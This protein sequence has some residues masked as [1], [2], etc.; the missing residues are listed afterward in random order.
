MRTSLH[1]TASTLIVLAAALALPSAAL[2]APTSTQVTSPANPSFVNVNSD[3]TSALRVAGSTSGGGGNVDLRCYSGAD[4]KLVAANVAVSDG[5]FATDVTLDKAQLLALGY[6]RPYCVL[7]AVPTGTTPAAPPGA[8]VWQG[9]EIGWGQNQ[10]MTLGAGF[11]PNPADTVRDY[12]IGQ[13]QSRAWNDADSVSSCGICD[14]YLFKPGTFEKANPIW[15]ANGGIY[16]HLTSAFPSTRSALQADG[17]DVY[18]ATSAKS[19]GLGASAGFPTLTSS[20]SVDPATGDLTIHEVSQFSSC[21][22][23]PTVHPPTKTSCSSF[24]PVL[25]LDRTITTSH[26]GLQVVIADAWS[27]ADGKAHEIDAWYDEQIHATNFATAGHQSLWNFSWTQDGF[28][29]YAADTQI[30]TGDGPLFIKTDGTTPNGG[31]GM[32]PIGAM[33]F[34]E[35]P[36]GFVMRE[37][38]TQVSSNGEWQVHYSKQVPA[39]GRATI[40]QAYS[41]DFAL[42]DVQA[43]EQQ[44]RTAIAA[45]SIAIGSPVGDVSVADASI[46]V[47]GTASSPDGHP[48]VTVN[49]KDVA[50]AGDGSWTTEVPLDEGANSIAAVVT[51]AVRVGSEKRLTVTRSTPAA[52]AADPPAPAAA[53]PVAAPVAKAVK[54]RVPKLRGKTL[55]RAKVLLKRAHCRIGKVTRKSSAKVRAGRV[56]ASRPKA[57]SVKRAGARI[58]LTLAKR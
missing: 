19:M 50:L 22:P 44:A 23:Q 34:S 12:F 20:K 25:R 15:Y 54:C 52:P 58:P 55:R 13:A 2:A 7:R 47:S 16:Y 40:A 21:S 41:H 46:T 4:S 30:P 43:L 5:L 32:N 18:A 53:A 42:A 24:Q 57:G 28:K 49:G 48:R 33:T 14:T 39:A 17:I 37:P 35:P 29:T 9:P 8:S 56:I 26:A 3:T 31:D 10:V 6:P 38:V 11:D 1:R 27:S 45:P 36:A 51:N